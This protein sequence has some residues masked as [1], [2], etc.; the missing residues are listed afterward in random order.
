[1][2]EPE[3]SHNANIYIGN[4]GSA[5]TEEHIAELLLPYGRVLK[6]VVPLGR[7]TGVRRGFAFVTMGSAAEAAA[8]AAVSSVRF[9]GRQLTLQHAV[10]RGVGAP[11]QARET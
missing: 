9:G 10:T 8:V 11:R 7:D 5:I 4:L 3:S 2:T 1:M 6:V